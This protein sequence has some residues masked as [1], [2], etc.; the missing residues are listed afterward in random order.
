MEAFQTTLEDCKLMDL[1]CRGQKFTWNNGR[2]GKEFIKERL[3]KVVANEAW[4]NVF[5]KVDINVKE[6]LSSDHCPIFVTLHDEFKRRRQ[7]HIFRHEAR[8]AREENYSEVIK[9]SWQK[10]GPR[11][12]PWGHL[13][14]RLGFCKQEL[15]RWQK[16]KTARQH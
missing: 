10:R 8:W 2:E 7:P 13:C 4:C 9:T 1:R 6:E 11:T 3:D 12:D 16:K 15:K 5:P 14:G